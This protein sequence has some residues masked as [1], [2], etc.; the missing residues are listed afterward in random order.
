MN[1]LDVLKAR[2]IREYP[3]ITAEELTLRLE[4]AIRIL[5]PIQDK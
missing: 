1:I 2:I 3:E 4:M 5:N